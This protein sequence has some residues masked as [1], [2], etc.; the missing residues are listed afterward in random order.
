MPLSC[1]RPSGHHHQ[2][3]MLIS[4][5]GRTHTPRGTAP[6]HTPDSF[7]SPAISQSCVCHG[8]ASRGITTT[9]TGHLLYIKCLSGSISFSLPSNPMSVGLLIFALYREG[10][11]LREVQSP[12]QCNTAAPSGA[13]LQPRTCNHKAHD[14]NHCAIP[15]S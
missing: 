13:D 8:N 12:V 10:E 6:A 1:P 7:L 3:R 5:T 9:K 11:R 14:F 15:S 2:P 4:Y